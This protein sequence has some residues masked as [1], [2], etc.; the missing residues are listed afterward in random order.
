MPVLIVLISLALLFPG[1]SMGKVT[2]QSHRDY[3]N[4]G[5]G[6]KQK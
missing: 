2:L 1:G 3:G 4:T 5:G 6:S